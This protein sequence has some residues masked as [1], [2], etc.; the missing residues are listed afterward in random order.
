MAAA[1]KTTAA[2][3]EDSG[4]ASYAS[5]TK[6][7]MTAMRPRVSTLGT[8]QNCSRKM[9]GRLKARRRWRSS[10]LSRRRGDSTGPLLPQRQREQ[11][12]SLARELDAPARGL[13]AG[14]PPH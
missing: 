9:L 2:Q 8:F 11:R 6:R 1:A 12:K 13:A 14:V 5:H 3:A 10:L 4:L 7:G